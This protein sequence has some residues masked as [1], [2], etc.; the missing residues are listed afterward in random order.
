[1]SEKRDRT[2]RKVRSFFVSI[3]LRASEVPGRGCP[4]SCNTPS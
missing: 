2:L 1:M 3:R 4:S